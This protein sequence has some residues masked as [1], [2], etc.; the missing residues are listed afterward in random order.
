MKVIVLGKC[1]TSEGV[2]LDVNA[3][4]DLDEEKEQKLFDI[5]LVREFN[6][7]TD[8]EVIDDVELLKAEIL[9]LDGFVKEAIGL[10]KGLIPEGYEG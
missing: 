5:G 2:F 4:P 9:K 7:D 6:E 1:L 8:V 3:T 10:K